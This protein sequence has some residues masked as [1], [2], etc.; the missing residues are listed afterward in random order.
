MMGLLEV[1]FSEIQQ[2]KRFLELDITGLHCLRMLMLML[3]NV[4]LVKEVLEDKPKQQDH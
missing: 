3:E 2:H 4:M 1:I